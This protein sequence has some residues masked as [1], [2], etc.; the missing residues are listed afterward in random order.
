MSEYLDWPTEPQPVA[1][2]DGSAYW[3]EPEWPKCGMHE[4][5]YP[6]LCGGSAVA[7]G[8]YDDEAYCA[9]HIAEAYGW[10]RGRMRRVQGGWYV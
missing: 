1:E 5:P 3:Q 4:G 10:N 9:E 2:G 8:L 7:V 6:E